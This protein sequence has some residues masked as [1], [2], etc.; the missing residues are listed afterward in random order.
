LREVRGDG[1]ARGVERLVAIEGAHGPG[2]IEVATT[3]AHAVSARQV[4]CGVSRWDASGLFADIA[5]SPADVR[6]VSPRTLLLLYAADLAFRLRWEI[7]PALDRGLIVIVAPYVTT[8]I[9]FGLATGLSPDWLQ[10]LFRFAPV[11]AHSAVLRERDPKRV[12][13]RRPERGFGE[14]CTTLLEDTTEGFARRKTR[15]AMNEVLATAVGG[16]CRLVRKRDL[17]TLAEELT[18]EPQRPAR[19]YPAGS[20]TPLSAPAGSGTR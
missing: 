5:S 13:K 12:W 10:T 6:D 19:P 1:R 18:T 16:R 4:A 8:A 15:R 14:C 3:L 2:V 7:R 17:T 11:P 20:P 9:A